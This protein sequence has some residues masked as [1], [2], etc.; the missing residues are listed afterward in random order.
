MTEVVGS[1]EEG[2]DLTLSSENLRKLFI[3]KSF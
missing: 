2:A 1:P 3:E